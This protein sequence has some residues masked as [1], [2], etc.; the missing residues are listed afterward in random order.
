M[1]PEEKIRFARKLLIEA[2][3]EIRKNQ[4]LKDLNDLCTCGHTR[5][6]HTVSHSIN[7]TGGMCTKCKCQN[8]LET[9]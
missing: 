3:I 5:K 8:F 7:Y 4:K 2:T 1:S 9:N 6:I